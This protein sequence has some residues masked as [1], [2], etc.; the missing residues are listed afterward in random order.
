MGRRTI[1]IVVICG[2][3][4]ITVWQALAPDR[5]AEKVRRQIR[6]GITFSEVLAV[7][8]GWFYCHGHP[9]NGPKDES[10]EMSPNG[11]LKI[12]T[13]QS[14]KNV[15]NQEESL[16]TLSQEM[17]ESGVDWVFDFGFIATPRRV[18]FLVTLGPD[19]RVK[20]VSD[21]KTVD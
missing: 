15:A 10:A 8:K 18:Y 16:Q 14:E 1:V 13:L 17:K 3:V 2:V 6:T 19:G 5:G 4:A 20:S 21:L 11:G 12:V 7:E 9:V